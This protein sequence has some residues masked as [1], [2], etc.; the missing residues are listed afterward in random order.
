MPAGSSRLTSTVNRPGF[1]ARWSTKP[2]SNHE[3]GVRVALSIF[4][5]FTIGIGPSSSHATGPMRAARHV[6]VE[7]AQISSL[8]QVASVEV[9]LVGSLAATGAGHGTAEALVLGLLGV[10]SHEIDP[11]QA[12]TMLRDVRNRGVVTLLGDHEVA[13]SE[14]DHVLC[15]PDELLPVHSRSEEHTSELQSLMSTSYAVFCLEKKN[16][17]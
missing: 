15:R 13:F 7:F 2:W 14:G 10:R 11:A 6:M 8:R 9:E 17:M 16:H 5:L 1:S 4:D 3:L 12:S